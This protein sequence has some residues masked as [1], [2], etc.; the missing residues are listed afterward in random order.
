[1]QLRRT[2]AGL[3]G[4]RRTVVRAADPRCSCGRRGQALRGGGGLGQGARGGFATGG[5]TADWGRGEGARGGVG[6]GIAAKGV[7]N[8]AQA[9]PRAW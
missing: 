1:V 5:A 2:G 8:R 7:T 9:E 3:T 4:R 6:P